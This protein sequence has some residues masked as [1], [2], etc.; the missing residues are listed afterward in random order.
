MGCLIRIQFTK[1]ASEEPSLAFIFK[2]AGFFAKAKVVSQDKEGGKFVVMVYVHW[3]EN[4]VSDTIVNVF[5]YDR[6]MEKITI[7]S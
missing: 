6:S 1:K 5:N 3:P 4:K 7:V 2:Y